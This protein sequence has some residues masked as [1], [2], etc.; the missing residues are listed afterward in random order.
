MI[1]MALAAEGVYL[2]MKANLFS[3]IDLIFGFTLKDQSVN[4]TMLIN[5]LIKVVKYPL[6]S[7]LCL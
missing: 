3:F 1:F 5:C 6:L 7:K 2:V 4:L